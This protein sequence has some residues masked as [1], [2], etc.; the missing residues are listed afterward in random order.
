MKILT[1]FKYLHTTIKLYHIL[2]CGDFLWGVYYI[3]IYYIL[4]I[5]H[6]LEAIYAFMK[7]L[8][9]VFS[10]KENLERVKFSKINYVKYNLERVIRSN[11]VLSYGL[12]NDQ[13]VRPMTQ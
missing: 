3:L 10:E 6:F 8:E 12:I 5:C 11:S 2:F 7:N 13:M 4:V 9:R 1:Y